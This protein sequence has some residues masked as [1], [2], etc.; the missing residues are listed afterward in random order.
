MSIRIKISEFLGR[1]K[2]TQKDL[3]D[4][5]GIR[6]ATVSAMYHETLRRL[7]LDHLDKLCMVFNCQP[8]DLLE[9]VQDKK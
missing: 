4:S 6:P 7:D 8:G 2:M 1:Y 3:A 9:F 5:T